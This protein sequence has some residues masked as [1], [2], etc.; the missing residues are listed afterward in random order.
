[1]RPTGVRVDD[2]QL[3]RPVLEVGTADHPV[4][5]LDRVPNVARKTR[6]P[7]RRVV[8]MKAA[9]LFD[10]RTQRGV[11]LLQPRATLGPLG[12]AP[13]LEERAQFR[14]RETSVGDDRKIDRLE[15]ADVLRPLARAKLHKPNLDHRAAGAYAALLLLRRPFLT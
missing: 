6:G 13:F 2:P 3:R 4:L 11:V 15:L 1:P 12:R 14:Q 8:P 10:F 7:D 5:C 9:L